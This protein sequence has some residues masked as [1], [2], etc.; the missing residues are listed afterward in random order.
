MGHQVKA[1]PDWSL[2]CGCRDGGRRRK[3]QRGKE[4]L[5]NETQ[6]TSRFQG[7]RSGDTIGGV[8]NRKGKK[9]LIPRQPGNKY[10]CWAAGLKLGS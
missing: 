4:H 5:T 9:R 7:H 2:T 8:K 1:A 6:L 3:G 10:D